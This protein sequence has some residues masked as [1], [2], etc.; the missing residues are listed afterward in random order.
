MAF[1]G[2]HEKYPSLCVLH[3]VREGSAR[4]VL[5]DRSGTAQ[6]VVVDNR[7]HGGFTG[8]LLGSVGLHLVDHAGCPV[9]VVR[10]RN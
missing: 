9:A 6:L 1:G 7:G 3:Y 4:R 2:I 10:H 5:A 8:L